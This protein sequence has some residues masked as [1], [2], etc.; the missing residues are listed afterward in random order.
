MRRVR[1]AWRRLRAVFARERLDRE[2]SDELESHLA[3]HIDD[4]LRA[5]MSADEARR[6]ALAKL[7]GVTQIGERHRERRGLPRLERLVGDVRYAARSLRAAPAFT[8]VAIITLGLGIG[9]NTAIFTV[10]NAALF[11]KFPVERPEELI[12]IDRAGGNIPTFSYPDYRDFRDRDTLLSSIAALRLAPMNVEVGGT[13]SRV[14]GYLVTGN[15]FD[16]LG[17]RAAKGRLL[18][19]SDDRIPGGHP[20]L[21]LSDDCWRTRFAAD[22]DIVGRTVKVNGAVFT[23]LGVATP[24]FRGTERLLTP[25]VWVPIMMVGHIE[26]G[27]DWLERRRTQNIFL[28]GRR[29]P[30]VSNA[31]AEASLNAVAADLA[32]QFPATHEGLRISVSPPGL[33]GGM[34]RGPVVGFSTALLGVAGLVLLLACTNLT[35]LLLAR[36]TDRRRE[37]AIRLSLG[38]S[39]PDLIR[40]AL[41]ESAL[42]SL[43]GAALA[44]LLA[45]WLAVALTSWRLPV[46][47]PLR[48]SVEIDARVFLFSASLALIS[49][50]LIGLVPALHGT[51][52]DVMPILKGDTTRVRGRWHA[53]DVIVGLQVALSTILLV[54][55]LLV[56]RS[57]QQATA[58]DV[59]YNPSGAVS[60]RID[61]GLHGYGRERGLS[62]QRRLVEELSAHPGIQSASLSNSIPLNL[63]VSTHTVFVEGQPAPKGSNIP[64]AIYYQ[65]TPGFFETLQTRLVAGRDLTANDTATSR[66]VAIVNQAFAKQFLAD[67]GAIGKRFR[68][69]PAGDWI[70]IVGVVADGKY[71]TLGEAPRAVAFHPGQQWFNPTTTILARTSLSD[72]EALDAIRRTVRALDPSLSLFEEGPLSQ[73]LALPLLPIQVAATMLGAFG[74]LAI[75][76]VLVGIYG[77]MSYAIAQRT[78]EICI[79][80]AVGA[81][82]RHIVRLVSARATIVWVLGVGAGVV[83]AGVA[84]PLLSPILL[85]PPRTAPVIAVACGILAVVI[86]VA[87]WLPTRRALVSDPSTLLRRS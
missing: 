65:V 80:L 69:G 64:N 33:L 39:R 36:S 61:L 49:T 12:A 84:A 48:L 4:N 3:L 27:N 5:G 50:L 77:L 82:P 44:T 9:A 16:M 41:A 24:G 52:V 56:I 7:G 22:P 74:A 85:S 20:V 47:V 68:S 55:S 26:S 75:V 30:G 42:L 6:H 35:G 66:R 10:I 59:G 25:E 83:A 46:D 40:R 43:V 58:I 70:E 73:Q 81:S 15:Y 57:L 63:D 11:Q 13:P 2:L 54:G 72:G 37:T 28:Q 1:A 31:Q 38:A 8:I 87:S 53:R 67:A 29:R 19:P 32:R 17:V 45:Q 34:L 78:R 60:A 51:R 76:L 14:W 23:I 71:Q 18:A 62:I 86:V 79:R 21:V